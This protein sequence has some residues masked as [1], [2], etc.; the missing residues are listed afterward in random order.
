MISELLHIRLSEA[1]QLLDGY[2]G[3]ERTKFIKTKRENAKRIKIPGS[4]EP[5][6]RHIDYLEGRGYNFDYLS[7]KYQLH[8]TNGLDVGWE[9]RVV[10]PIYYNHQVVSYQARDITGKSSIRY[11]SATPE[12]SLIHYKEVIFGLDD[13]QGSVCGIV[14]GAYDVF[15]MGAG[16][17]TGF[18]SALRS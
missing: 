9:H 1:I 12:E 16:V 17:G 10:L 5:R 6:Q 13:W 14:E 7:D 11:R 4:R 2:G 8:Y 3:G 18:G 15:R